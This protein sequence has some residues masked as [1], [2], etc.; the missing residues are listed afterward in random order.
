MSG[1]FETSKNESLFE[2]DGDDFTQ[3]LRQDYYDRLIQKAEQNRCGTS[4]LSLEKQELEPFKLHVSL[5]A[6]EYQTYKAQIV[7]RIERALKAGVINMAKWT[8]DKYVKR[9]ND[10]QKLDAHYLIG[11]QFTIYIQKNVNKVDVLALCNDIQ[12][13][14]IPAKPGQPAQ[15]EELVSQ[16]ISCRQDYIKK[17]Q[18][19]VY[20]PAIPTK[21]IDNA[22]LLTASAELKKQPLFRFLDAYINDPMTISMKKAKQ[23]ISKL[24]LIDIEDGLVKDAIQSLCSKLRQIL[25]EI[26]TSKSSPEQNLCG[27]DSEIETIRNNCTSSHLLK[28]IALSILSVIGVLTVIGTLPVLVAWKKNIED[29]GNPFVFLDAI[30]LHILAKNTASAITE[31]KSHAADPSTIETKRPNPTS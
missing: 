6:D 29:V 16:H 11:D 26:K 2:Q 20:V 18:Y 27:L 9:K 22:D 17:D 19:Y 13:I 8:N 23:T 24:E 15:S 14:L 25:E 31:L 1:F 10:E 30:K 7:A 4:N 3:K 28:N 5:S 12:Q 21:E